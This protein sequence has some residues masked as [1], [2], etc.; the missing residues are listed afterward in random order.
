MAQVDVDI[1]NAIARN[2]IA[3]HSDETSFGS[4]NQIF[5]LE[6]KI[7]EDINSAEHVESTELFD[8]RM[9]S[10][11]REYRQILGPSIFDDSVEQ[12]ILA[13]LY[14]GD[15][16]G[17]FVRTQAF[18]TILIENGITKNPTTRLL[19]ALVKNLN[20]DHRD[21]LELAEESA[22]KAADKKAKKEQRKKDAH[23]Q[24]LSSIEHVQYKTALEQ[25]SQ[26]RVKKDREDA[27]QLKREEH[28]AAKAYYAAEKASSYYE[29]APSASK[30]ERLSRHQEAESKRA[31]AR[32]MKEVPEEIVEKISRL[33]VSSSVESSSNGAF[34]LRELYNLRG[35]AFNID[36]KIESNCWDFRRE[37]LVAYYSAM[38][39]EQK[40]GKGSHEKIDFTQSLI[41]SKNGEVITVLTDFGGALTLPY[42]ENTVPHYL[43]KQIN[44][45]RAALARSAEKI[46]GKLNEIAGNV[47]EKA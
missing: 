20:G 47:H 14:A 25:E 43:R 44:I 21:W 27:R 31:E 11:Y 10:I 37:D 17:A 1:R 2:K 7:F 30:E 42:W 38:G 29:E 24:M 5:A 8:E 34:N 19:M 3:A 9:L 40:S 18:E 46:V 26:L 22:K 39:C 15:I 12:F 36:E 35:L 13:F 33:T 6:N 4:L 32:V 16:D 41:F 28:K 45:A 23:A